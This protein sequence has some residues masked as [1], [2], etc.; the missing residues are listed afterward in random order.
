ME[1][2]RQ[3]CD[4][5][6]RII[7]ADDIAYCIEPGLRG[8]L[9]QAINRLKSFKTSTNSISTTERISIALHRLDLAFL[10]R[11]AMQRGASWQALLALE[12]QWLSAPVPS[13]CEAGS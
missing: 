2:I 13:S 6:F 3:R 7:D 8:R 1:D 5:T 11:D 10:Q 9:H 4:A 12:Q